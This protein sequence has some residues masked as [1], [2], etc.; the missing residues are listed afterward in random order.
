MNEAIYKETGIELFDGNPLIESIID[1]IAMSKKEI[2]RKLYKRI[3]WD[4]D[5]SQYT[6][7]EAGIRIRNIREI[8]IPLEFHI[9]I[10]E[11]LVNMIL[12]TY[13][14]RNPLD[15][16]FVRNRNQRILGNVNSSRDYKGLLVSGN[17][18]LGK[19]YGIEAIM[20]SIGSEAILHTAY[21]G[22][23]ISFIMI[24]IIKVNM[25]FTG[26]TK[27]LMLD[28]MKQV[29][30]KADTMYF[31]ESV[32]KRYTNATLINLISM[33]V[34]NHQ[35]GC[36]VI[37]ELQFA[38]DIPRLLSFLTDIVNK[39]NTSFVFMGTPSLY[40][41]IDDFAVK[42]RISNEGHIVIDSMSFDEYSF[43]M[44]ELFKYR[45]GSETPEDY[46]ALTRFF[47]EKTDGNTDL[48]FKLYIKSL[49]YQ[50]DNSIK[51]M[52]LHDFDAI[53]KREFNLLSEEIIAFKGN[54]GCSVKR[55][56]DI[57]TKV[58]FSR[59]K[60]VEKQ[61]EIQLPNENYQ[62][63]KD[64]NMIINLDWCLC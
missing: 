19:S 33:I 44:A 40:S 16:E 54:K 31:S 3:D 7:I 59:V 47:Y 62:S 14:K 6:K 57:F 17:S 50:L 48:T 64:K 12:S 1:N 25:N 8:F 60:E 24:P 39:I 26:S 52:A 42:R 36:I 21:K 38:K 45:C 20:N 56:D 55:C 5:L 13:S 30:T 53:Y 23:S 27:N 4:E 41:L 29:D 35:I 28:I 32:S 18:G 63:Y 46:E 58:N 9:R 43:F 51:K 15:P 2:I 22:K 49:E 10:Y 34:L 11:N 61:V 37:D